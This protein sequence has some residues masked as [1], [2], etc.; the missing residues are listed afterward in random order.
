MNTA[1]IALAFVYIIHKLK[2]KDS[3]G[4][5]LANVLMSSCRPSVY[6]YTPESALLTNSV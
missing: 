3:N 2:S 1:C 5:Q 6:Q 4:S